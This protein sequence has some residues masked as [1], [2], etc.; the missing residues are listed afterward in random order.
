MAD[1]GKALGAPVTVSFGGKEYKISPF[2]FNDLAE[3]ED[4]FGSLGEIDL[5]RV[6]MQRFIVF[7]ALRKHRPEMSEEGAGDILTLDAG[8]AVGEFIG[9]IMRGSGLTSEN[10]E[11]AEASKKD[12]AAPPTKT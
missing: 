1:L 9:S 10:P 5:T 11:D 2:T 7:L 3:I 12:G 4:R 6:K 8:A